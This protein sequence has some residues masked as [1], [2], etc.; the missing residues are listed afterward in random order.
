MPKFIFQASNGDGQS[1]AGELSADD[2]SAAVVELEGR[3]LTVE[4]IRLASIAK[5]DPASHR[6]AN[7]EDPADPSQH[8]ALERQFSAAMDRREILMPAL[9]ALAED[10]P[11][12]RARREIRQLV[13]VLRDARSAEDLRRSNVATHWLPL[14]VTGFTSESG[15][16]RL[17]NLVA[18][19]SREAENRSHRRRLLA[20]PIFLFTVAFAIFA[21]LCALVVPTFGSMFHEFGLHLPMSTR[22]V[23]TI[24]EQLTERPIEFVITVVIIVAVAYGLVRLWAHFAISTRLFGI[25][26]AG[27]TSNVSAMSS[28]TSQLA[29]LLS[30]NVSLSDALWIA[31]KGC[32]D[33]HFK[34]VAAQLARHTHHSTVA[35]SES[36]FAH[37]LPAN[38][39]YA[40]E[41]NP[42]GSP[43]VPLL[44]ELSAMYSDR[45]GQRVDWS[46]GA[47]AQVA[48]LVVGLFVGFVVIALFSPLVSLITGLS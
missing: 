33:Y 5:E 13:D 2:V 22:V 25:F 35:L 4:S 11:S 16:S 12:G 32:G 31:G 3:G 28:L 6:Q 45:A 36:P 7:R 41:A 8:S 48:I 18:H 23:V 27:N 46:T 47:M 37:N 20:Y 42:D 9:T 40:L 30:I 15:A 17:S 24:A 38:V 29:E 43:N 21:S 44:R 34:K 14:L 10:I 39:I 19:T 26:T 1:V